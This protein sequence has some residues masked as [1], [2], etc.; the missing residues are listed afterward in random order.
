M[1]PEDQGSEVIAAD[2]IPLF[3]ERSE[4]IRS[5]SRHGRDREMGRAHLIHLT[6]HLREVKYPL[7]AI[8]DPMPNVMRVPDSQFKKGNLRASTSFTD[9]KIP[10]TWHIA[11]NDH[12]R[13]VMSEN[14]QDKQGRDFADAGHSI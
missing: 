1:Y 2:G 4:E 12:V 10:R 13:E 9:G 3:E 6:P 5:Y 14:S 7:E 8:R 11:S